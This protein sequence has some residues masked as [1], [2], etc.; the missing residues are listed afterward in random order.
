ML[1]WRKYT[2]FLTGCAGELF[3]A[4]AQ[5][6]LSRWAET[7]L[8]WRKQDIRWNEVGALL[9]Q[10]P[11]PAM[12][13][14]LAARIHRRISQERNKAARVTWT[15]R[16]KNRLEPFAIPA[17]AGLLSALFIFGIF[18]R[19]FEI[20][21]QAGS[22]DVPLH[23]RTPPRLRTTAL[24]ETNT[25]IK[26]ME[27][28]LLI[29]QNG[30]VADYKILKGK[31]TPEQLRQLE[32]LLVFTVFDPATMFGKPTTETVTLALRDGYLKG[33]SL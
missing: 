3:P 24:M 7:W 28:A 22:A 9:K 14:D 12:P 18:I 20:P 31:Q 26:C 17:A 5:E 1:D 29:D 30:R 6:L 13:G 19:I 33:L 23:F 4:S 10:M 16:W 32:Y 2:R 21:V 25:G 8:G 15:W 11:V 27:V